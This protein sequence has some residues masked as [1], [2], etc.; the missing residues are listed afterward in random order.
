[1]IVRRFSI[2]PMLDW[3][4]RHARF[5]LRLFSPNILLYTEMVTCGALLHGDRAR[6]L[7]HHHAEHPVAIQLGGSDPE[8]LAD[9]AGLAEAAGFD[10]VNLNVGCPSE[11]VQSGRFGACLMAE[12]ELVAA[13]VEAMNRVTRIPVTV[14][15][16]IGIDHQDDYPFFL[17]FVDTVAAGGCR[18]F[19][20]HARKAWLK[21]LSP[22]QNRELPPLDY[23]AV[24]R[25]KRDRD[26][27]EVIVNGGIMNITEASD[28]LHH[29]DGVMMG[30]AAFQ[31]PSILFDVDPILF[32]ST[33]RGNDRLRILRRYLEYAGDE[34]SN[35]VALRHLTPPLLG[36]FQGQPGTKVWKRYI[37][38]H[39][40][41]EG[42][43]LDVLHE[44]AERAFRLDIAA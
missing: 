21:G 13:C 37:A 29:V 8:Q 34:L 40:H 22:K 36:L 27:L 14:K 24:Y 11:R 9:C 42:A 26:D 23:N 12:P 17:R 25:L 32:G 20:V 5:F 16:R 38:E 4:D 2:A 19:I 28:H 43:G 31:N 1:M 35:G 18:S 15:C 41:Q 10:E 33:P 6:F 39:G 30:R 7:G 44:A 3:T